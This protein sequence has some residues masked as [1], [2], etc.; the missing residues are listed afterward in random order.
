M[1]RRLCFLTL[2]LAALTVVAALNAAEPFQ[3][4]D[5]KSSAAQLEE[6]ARRQKVLAERYRKFEEAL[7][8]LHDRLSG[9]SEADKERAIK[10][11]AALDR[12]VEGSI[13]ERFAKF[14]K[15]LSG[16]VEDKEFA[17]LTRQS[18]E[19]S[20]DLQDVLHLL[21]GNGKK[22][23]NHKEERLSLEAKIKK[24]D[25]L[26]RKEKIVKGQIEIGLDPTQVKDNQREVTEATKNLAKKLGE[27]DKKDGKDDKNKG[28]QGGEAKN[29]KSEAK[30][31]KGDGNKGQSKDAGKDNKGSEA[32]PG[33]AKNQ[34]DK[35]DA[36]PGQSKEGGKDSKSGKGSESKPG[37]SKSGKGSESK[38]GQ[39]KD[40][41][42]SKG[43]E[44]QPKESKK[45]GKGQEGEAKDGGK[46]DGQEKASSLKTK[47]DE[48]KAGGD[49]KK[50]EGSAKEGQPG[51][52]KKEGSAKQGQQGGDKK[53]S[54]SKSGQQSE[55]KS[56]QGQSK[57]GE[58][59]KG[60]GQPKQGAGGMQD[61]DQGSSKKESPKADNQPPGKQDP[62]RHVDDA[63][64]K[65]KDPRRT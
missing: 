53:G 63:I 8:N 25:E 39:S 57:S 46:K 10:L 19:L 1:L 17:A 44:G 40:G 20:R 18:E 52:E 59:S 21:E 5:Q 47:E 29:D 16:T 50:K 58:S 65:Q 61:D 33:D 28:G 54:E 35:K 3:T 41:K 43:S 2:G 32:K 45:D 30:E 48:K 37:D 55:S 56:S 15:T 27:G 4:K 24:L 42:G 31:A 64:V 38:S 22:L 60:Q 26:I 7:Q 62:Q 14:T 9:G 36:K 6:L 12:S 23:V 49:D 34:G 11:K 13:S 51:G